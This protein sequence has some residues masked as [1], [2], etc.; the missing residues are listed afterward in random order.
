MRTSLFSESLFALPL[1]DAIKSTAEIGFD[2]I[3]L[4]CWKPH[5][6]Y[7]MTARNAE[8]VAEWIRDAGLAVSA[9]SLQLGGIET[10][11]T[12]QTISRDQLKMAETLIGLAPVFQTNLI[13]MNP[14]PPASRDAEE[15]HW[16]CLADA[17]CELAAMA[18]EAGVKLAF[19]STLRQLTD[20]LSSTERFL[21]MAPS[22][23]MGVTVD[24]TNLSFAGESAAPII[25]RLKGRIYHTH[26]K[27][28]RMGPDGSLTFESLDTGPIDYSQVLPLLDAA[29]YDGYL[30][31]ESRDRNRQG[32]PAQIAAQKDLAI[33]NRYLD[34][35][36]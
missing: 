7:P 25:S 19:H 16:L 34:A 6:D 21:E 20:T 17:V 29:G 32:Y 10:G 28:A 14:G 35:N 26:L 27:N 15:K 18:R 2:A 30:S 36:G 12:D 31:I 8:S 33:L 22:D 24:F 5:F 11:F 4:A 23:C 1:Q 3:E 9:L 13:Q